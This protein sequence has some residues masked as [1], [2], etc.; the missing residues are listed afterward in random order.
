[1]EDEIVGQDAKLVELNREITP[2]INSQ[3]THEEQAGFIAAVYEDELQEGKI[4]KEE[5]DKAI[6]FIYGEMFPGVENPYE[7]QTLS[8]VFHTE[9]HEFEF[10]EYEFSELLL[11]LME[12]FRKKY[13]SEDFRKE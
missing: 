12:D 8:G 5:F 7:R 1:M 4:T 2:I 13:E 10:R 3:P 11:E 9:P 6:G